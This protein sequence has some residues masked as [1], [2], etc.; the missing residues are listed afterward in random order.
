MLYDNH[1]PDAKKGMQYLMGL[2]MGFNVTF[3]NYDRFIIPADIPKDNI[4]QQDVEVTRANGSK[5]FKRLFL[6]TKREQ[7]QKFEL[8]YTTEEATYYVLYS[9]E[10][11]LEELDCIFVT[12][13]GRRRQQYISSK[14]GHVLIGNDRFLEICDQVENVFFEEMDKLMPPEDDLEQNTAF[15][16]KLIRFMNHLN[17]YNGKKVMT[18]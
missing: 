9:G 18:G 17:T 3:C 13:L 8:E 7:L 11:S 10:L 4:L 12:V 14:H 5:E 6:Y 15:S 16:A 1:S 2:V